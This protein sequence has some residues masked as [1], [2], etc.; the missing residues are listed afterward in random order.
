MQPIIYDVAVSLDGF[1]AGPGGDVSHFAHD[2]PVVDDYNDRLGG[3]AIA[4]MGR[5]TYEFGYRYGLK[6][7]QNPY[8][9]MKTYVFSRTLSVPDQSDVTVMTATTVDTIRRLQQDAAGPIYLCGGG[10]FAGA[11]IDM[12]L[13]TQV[14]LKR[15][16]IVM[17]TGT[18]LFGD[19]GHSSALRRI[20][21]KSYANGYLLETFEV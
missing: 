9:H 8:A 2:G 13:I 18:L 5:A 16:P 20:E 10:A 4:I 3:Y 14:R 6:P 12:G 15:A 1:I 21:T 19:Q 11:L 7:G 17:G